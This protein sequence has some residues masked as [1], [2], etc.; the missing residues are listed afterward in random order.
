VESKSKYIAYLFP[1]LAWII[2]CFGFSFDGLYG[3]DAYEYL[4]YT[5]A[6][7]SFFTIGK[8]PGDYFWGIYY[9][10]IGSVLSFIVSKTA[11]A[12]QLISVLSLCIGSI[13]L[14][15]IIRLVYNPNTTQNIPFLFFTLSPFVLVYS[16][17]VMS[18]MF[19]CGL[20]IAAVYHLLVFV[21]KEAAKNLVF[22][23]CLVMLAILTR[24]AAAVILFPFCVL[25]L[26]H[27]IKNRNYIYPIISLIAAGL[28]AVPHIVIRSQ[29]SLQFLSHEWLAS[30]NIS[31]LFRM[32]FSTVDGEMH[33]NCINLIYTFFIFFHPAFLVFGFVLVLFFL[34]ARKIEL[35]KYQTLFLIAVILYSVFLAGI[36]FQNKRFLTLAFPFA[37]VFLF[38]LIKQLYQR[39]SHP[40][41]VFTIIALIQLSL[42]VYYGKSFYDRNL[43]ERNIA[44]EIEKYNGSTIYAFDIDIALKSRK[45]DFNYRSLWKE[46]HTGFEK[47]ALL[48]VNEKQLKKQW[49]GKNPLLNWQNAKLNYHLEKLKKMDGDFNL[50]RIGERK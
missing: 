18:D 50:Y 38:P 16:V 1:I 3:Q 40:K 25:V 48:L 33:Y 14:E 47:N 11:M 5:E 6:L 27:I 17:L 32:Q 36:P 29:N 10:I 15:K 8:T 19:A 2:V 12:L 13:Y 42:A 9:P 46:K 7:K 37:I 24:Y 21:K 41:L 44:R 35:G 39:L 45:P 43:L 34:K 4:R 28:I 31:N 22:G 23:T 26:I 20:T 30:W 49:K